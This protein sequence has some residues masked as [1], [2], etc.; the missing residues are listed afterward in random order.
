M[1]LLNSPA[2][3]LEIE[4]QFY[5]LAPLLSLIF[6]ID[7]P[8]LRRFLTVIIILLSSILNNFYKFP[9]LNVFA[10]LEYFFLGFLL[11]D[12]YILFQPPLKRTNL[13]VLLTIFSFIALWFFDIDDTFTPAHKLIFEII[14]LTL[15]FILYFCVIVKKASKA[16]SWIFITN[17]GGMCYTIYL[18]H[19]PL[20]SLIG[21]FL[22]HFSL[23][24]F[25]W[26]NKCF[27]LFTILV[28]L[29]LVSSAF[30][31][32]IERP[33]MDKVWVNKNLNRIGIFFK[34]LKSN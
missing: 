30:F 9:F 22:V 33:F 28:F 26:I 1:P 17:I 6:R 23:S 12:I 14:L 11:V 18:I 25:E 5:I 29:S 4:F 21:N 7:P 8:I 15:I 32:L 24:K 3:S 34:F 10:F 31:L 16:F 13:D 20:I 27:Y 19:F 2:W